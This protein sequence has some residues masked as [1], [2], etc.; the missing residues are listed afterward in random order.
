MKNYKECERGF[1]EHHDEIIIGMYGPDGV[2]QGEC[3]VQWVMLADKATPYLKA[4]DDSW[5]ALQN[6]RDLLDWMGDLMDWMASVEDQ[7][8]TS[9][10]FAE[11]LRSLG[12]K[13][14]T[15]RKQPE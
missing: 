14:L 5:D 10:A 7:K 13:D 3:A 1:S 15:Q 2:T 8:I 6:F 4:Y 12:F 9:Q 11:A